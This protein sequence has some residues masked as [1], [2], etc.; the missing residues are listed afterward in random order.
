MEM[1][2]MASFGEKLTILPRFKLWLEIKRDSSKKIVLGKGKADIL[3]AIEN[4]GSIKGAAE[5]LGLNFK[6]AWRRTVELRRGDPG[7]LMEVSKGGSSKGGTLLTPTG[8]QL[9]EQYRQLE[10]AVVRTIAAHGSDTIAGFKAT[11]R[12][13]SVLDRGTGKIILQLELPGVIEVELP[14]FTGNDRD[15]T[16]GEKINLEFDIKLDERPGNKDKKSNS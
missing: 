13:K 10:R 2:T 1:F 12:I 3:E 6:T 11:A 15:F 7:F 16:T 5:K 8:Q 4:E 14:W 9:L